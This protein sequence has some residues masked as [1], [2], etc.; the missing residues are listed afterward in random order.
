MHIDIDDA[1][2][3]ADPYVP[4]DCE[5]YSRYELAIMHRRTLRLVWRDEAGGTHLETVLPC[6]LQTR[7]HQEFLLAETLDGE[8][9]CLRL[10]RIR[11]VDFL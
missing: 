10:D 9:R 1:D 6:D 8:P 2:P 11:H 7:M 4:I 3:A 5:L